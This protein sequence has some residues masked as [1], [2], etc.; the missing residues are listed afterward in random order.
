ME[1][2]LELMAE[3]LEVDAADLSEKTDFRNECDF[4]SLKGFSMICM[5]EDEYG[6]TVSVDTFLKCR[7]I[8]DL[9]EQTK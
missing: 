5:I 8:G 4:D 3:I 1:K 2:F 7:T 9:F 6:K